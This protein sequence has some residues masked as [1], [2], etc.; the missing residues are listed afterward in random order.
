MLELHPV[1]TLHQHQ[2]NPIMCSLQQF[3]ALFLSAIRV[4][5]VDV[6]VYAHGWLWM[7]VFEFRMFWTMC[8]REPQ[9]IKGVQCTWIPRQA[10]TVFMV[11]TD[12]LRLIRGDYVEWVAYFYHRLTVEHR[13]KTSQTSAYMARWS[14]AQQSY[15]VGSKYLRFI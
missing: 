13:I 2:R 5:S 8:V 6:C 15:T 9:C 11:A 1:M 14:T 4:L 10:F 3:L 12:S 7:W